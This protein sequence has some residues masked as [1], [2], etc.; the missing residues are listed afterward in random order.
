MIIRQVVKM[1]KNKKKVAVHASCFGCIHIVGVSNICTVSELVK[2]HQ[3]Q[4][5]ILLL[6]DHMV[7]V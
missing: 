2:P 3:R 6:V 1:F 5:D 7:H 4:G